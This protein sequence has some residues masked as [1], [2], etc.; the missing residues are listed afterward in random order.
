M[1]ESLLSPFSSLYSMLPQ[2]CSLADSRE[3]LKVFWEKHAEQAEEGGINRNGNHTKSQ[4]S[5]E[6]DINQEYVNA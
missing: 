5:R 1:I 2:C 6:V 4:T 3:A